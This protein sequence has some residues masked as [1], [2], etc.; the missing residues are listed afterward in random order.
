[1]DESVLE[2]PGVGGLGNAGVEVG[3]VSVPEVAELGDEPGRD[4]VLLMFGQRTVGVDGDPVG[5]GVV[6]GSSVLAGAEA[7]PD[8]GEA[9]G[10]DECG[11]GLP[12]DVVVGFVGG[13]I[14]PVSKWLGWV[15]VTVC[16]F[17]G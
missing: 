8:G 7:E 6:P 11:G 1:M 2:V 15:V 17:C 3:V 9:S 4:R 13:D 10:V 16:V 5:G 14:E 12:V